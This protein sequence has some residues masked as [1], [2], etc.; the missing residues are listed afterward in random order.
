MHSEQNV[1]EQVVMTGFSKNSLQT[2]QRRAASRGSNA[3]RDVGIQSVESGS[4]S[5]AVSRG[6]TSFVDGEDK[7]DVWDTRDAMVELA[8][9]RV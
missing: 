8:L 7:G 5:I 4:C 3:G 2:S 1:C 9:S 6:K